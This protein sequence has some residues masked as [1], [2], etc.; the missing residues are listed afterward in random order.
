[1]KNCVKKMF[2]TRSVRTGSKSYAILLEIFIMYPEIKIK[3]FIFNIIC[4]E[5]LKTFSL[6]KCIFSTELFIVCMLLH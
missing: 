6:L 2:G 1:M 3:H 4:V 5:I